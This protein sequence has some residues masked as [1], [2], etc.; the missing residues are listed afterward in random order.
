MRSPA[1][2]TRV[3]AEPLP[4]VSVVMPAFDEEAF[5]A[6]AIASVAAQ[7]YP[8]VELIVVDDG[9]RDRTGEIAAGLG[10]CVITWAENRGEAA[11]RNAG[12]AGSR[13]AY[14]TV[15]DA[16]D[17]MPPGRLEA[18]VAF[19]EAEPGVDMVL[20]LTE[21][22]VTPG[23]PRPPFW[24]PAWD[25]GPFPACAGTMMARREVFDR[26][27]PYD[28]AFVVSTDVDWLARAKDLRVRAG[29]IDVVCLRYRIHAGGAS[30]DRA[31]VGQAQLA[32]LRAS[33]RR[34]REQRAAE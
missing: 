30:A 14:W 32:L 6:E 13:G 28:P 15:F 9:S 22:F 34:T 7:T 4:L 19:L 29:A 27:G 18:Q 26:V 8:A 5:I 10:A 23:E 3:P 12:I 1:G 25:D 2:R 11:G 31:A 16:D 21:A 24:N 20:G 33:L 17:V